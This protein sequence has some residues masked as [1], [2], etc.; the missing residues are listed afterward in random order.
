MPKKPKPIAKTPART[1]RDLVNR[2]HRGKIEQNLVRAP[3]ERDIA[4]VPKKTRPAYVADEMLLHERRQL[5]ISIQCGVGPTVREGIDARL[6]EIDRELRHRSTL[7]A[8]A[9]ARIAA[10]GK[11][12]PI[13]HALRDEIRLAVEDAVSKIN[14][15]FDLGLHVVRERKL[16]EVYIERE[17]ALDYAVR[18]RKTGKPD[19]RA[20]D[21]RATKRRLD[22]KSRAMVVA[23]NKR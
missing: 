8:D 22:D 5:N 12:P 1:E 10:R 18:V 2:Y 23:R 20:N 13:T 14:R 9:E 16:S 4:G 17:G 3:G 21:R 15:A 11:E 6:R 19:R 7:I